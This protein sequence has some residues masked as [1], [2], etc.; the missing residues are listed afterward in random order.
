MKLLR[1]E[2]GLKQEE[3]ALEIDME[4]SEISRLESGVRRPRL[5]TMMKVAKRL[6]IR[7]SEMIK[8]AERLEA[9]V[10]LK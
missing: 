2:A 9:R 3:L 8:L 10:E 7:C 6:N 1:E 4:P 5:D